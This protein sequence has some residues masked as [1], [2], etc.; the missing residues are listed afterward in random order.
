MNG[1]VVLFLEEIKKVNDIVESGIVLNN[2]FVKIFPL[3][4]PAR[5]VLQSNVLLFISDDLLPSQYYPMGIM[6]TGPGAHARG[7]HGL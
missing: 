3:V 5:K 6:G 7:L 1:T 4:N 2:R